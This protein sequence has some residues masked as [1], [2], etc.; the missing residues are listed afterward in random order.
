M[1]LEPLPSVKSYPDDEPGEVSGRPTLG[2]GRSGAGLRDP[3]A[4]RNLPD[5]DGRGAD[6]RSERLRKLSPGGPARAWLFCPG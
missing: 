1:L 4:E 3:D 2:P 6:V 5:Y